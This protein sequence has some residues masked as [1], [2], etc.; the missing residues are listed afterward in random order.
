MREW[1]TL[2]ADTP[3][4]LSRSDLEKIKSLNDPISLKEVEEIYLPLSRLLSYYVEF[5]KGAEQCYPAL[6]G[7][8]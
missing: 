1:A 8:Q 5:A 7:H 2:R 3:L 6:S 4:T